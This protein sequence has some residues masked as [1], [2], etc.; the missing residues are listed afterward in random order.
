MRWS[1][2]IFCVVVVLFYYMGNIIYVMYDFCFYDVYILVLRCFW[3]WRFMEFWVN[4]DDYCYFR[5]WE[6][7][8]D[9]G[10]YC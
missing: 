8:R 6:G 2:I 5:V 7:K 9:G 4:F 10:F 3:Y 1:K